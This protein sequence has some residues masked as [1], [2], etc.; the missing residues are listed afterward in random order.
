MAGTR[1]PTPGRSGR[2]GPRART[3]VQTRAPRN[4]PSGARPRL[5]EKLTGRR[6][7]VPYRCRASGRNLRLPEKNHLLSQRAEVSLLLVPRLSGWHN[8]RVGRIVLERVADNSMEVLL[9][10]VRHNSRRQAPHRVE[11]IQDG[12]GGLRSHR[13][14]EDVHRAA[15]FVRSE[16]ERRRGEPNLAVRKASE[17]PGPV[18]DPAKK[19]VR[20]SNAR[21]VLR[22]RHRSAKTCP[23]ASLRR[24]ES[25]GKSPSTVSPVAS[26]SKTKRPVVP[27]G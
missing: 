2:Q 20:I 5:Q 22:R 16:L 19:R 10:R 1:N 3:F 26:L 6:S 17:H 14:L 11:T 15:D 12:E 24:G 4:S 27:S 18:R 7:I 21:I 8:Q 9:A 23:S 25:A 13:S